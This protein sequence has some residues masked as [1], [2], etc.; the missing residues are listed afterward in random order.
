MTQSRLE[1]EQWATSMGQDTRHWYD[2]YY[3]KDTQFLWMGWSARDNEI[4]ALSALK[5]APE[6]EPVKASWDAEGNPLNFQAAVRDAIDFIEIREPW[7]A[8][9]LLRKFLKDES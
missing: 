4:L 3:N 6:V 1:F 2:D 8:E 5:A 9:K 7:M